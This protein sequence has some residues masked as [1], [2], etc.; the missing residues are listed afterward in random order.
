MYGDIRSYASKDL[1][2]R[3]MKA[4]SMGMTASTEY[5]ERFGTSVMPLSYLKEKGF[6][7]YKRSDG[8][9]LTPAGQEWMVKYK[10]KH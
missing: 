7:K 10:C 1:L 9:S 3:I 2:Y 4:I 5:K 8:Y 6:V